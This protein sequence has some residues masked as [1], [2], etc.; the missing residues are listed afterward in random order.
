LFFGQFVLKFW[1]LLALF[2]CEVW[3][4]AWSIPKPLIYKVA[5]G[6]QSRLER[7]DSASRPHNLKAPSALFSK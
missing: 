2:S 4:N 3:S 1:L 6:L 5:K 7:F